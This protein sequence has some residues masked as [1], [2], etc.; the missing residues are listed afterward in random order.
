MRRASPFAPL[1]LIAALS[2]A[3]ATAATGC[4]TYEQELQRAEQ[5]FTHDEHERSLAT[6]RALESDWYRFGERD[7]ARYAYLRGMTDYR[8]GFKSDA[9][10]W[11]AIAAQ[12]DREHP[13]ALVAS[14]RQLVDEK[15]GELNQL[16][17]GGDVLP[18]EETPGTKPPKKVQTT[19]AEPN[20]D[21][22][23]AEESP[24]P[25]KK[26]AEAEADDSPK[27]KKKQAAED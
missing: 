13:G 3:V 1:V 23:D 9:R 7:R 14:E 10:H 2:T 11:L 17:W 26:A 20:G 12:I 18:Q 27:P 8:I 19:P 21:E 25:K 5:H 24:K 22:A 4:A 16:V 15:L 6:L